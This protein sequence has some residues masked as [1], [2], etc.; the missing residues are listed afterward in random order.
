MKTVSIV[1]RRKKEQQ[2][3]QQRFSKVKCLTMFKCNCNEDFILWDLD[4][5]EFS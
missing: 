2:Q 3:Q 1:C 5:W 4:T